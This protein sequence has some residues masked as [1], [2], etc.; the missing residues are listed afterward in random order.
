MVPRSAA[1]MSSNFTPP[2]SLG[3]ARLIGMRLPRTIIIITVA[4]VGAV[5]AL[6]ALRDD[7][8]EET[9]PI[10][11][12][13]TAAETESVEPEVI[14]VEDVDAGAGGA[15]GAAEK[16]KPVTKT[17]PIDPFKISKCC[18]A[19]AQNRQLAPA[20]QKGLYAAAAE[21]CNAA[22]SNPAVLA[23]VIKLLPSAPLVC[24]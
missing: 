23:R 19:L 6:W 9:I 16:A 18:A 8:S 20:E 7:E 3:V 22:R 24:Q 14:E 13:S 15:G 4:C 11:T 17:T 12:T 21:A 10:I 2:P 1:S 5:V